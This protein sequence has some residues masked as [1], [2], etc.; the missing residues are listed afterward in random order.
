MIELMASYATTADMSCARST[1]IPH[2][3]VAISMAMAAMMKPSF[4][5]RCPPAHPR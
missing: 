4:I 3:M 5:A 2:G 1:T